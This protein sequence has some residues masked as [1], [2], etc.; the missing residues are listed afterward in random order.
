MYLF[1]KNNKKEV[2]KMTN[3]RVIC[4]NGTVIDFNN[5][6]DISIFNNTI[7]FEHNNYIDSMDEPF[8]E[9]TFNKDFIIGFYEF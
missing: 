5:V 7:T 2:L 6:R 8:K 1:K 9:A 3:L 4:V